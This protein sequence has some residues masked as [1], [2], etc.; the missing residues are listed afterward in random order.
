[1]SSQSDTQFQSDGEGQLWEVV[2]IT[3]EKGKKYK[4]QWAG[5]DEHGKPWPESWV[6][7]H[8]CTPDL[9]A[10]W[11]EKKAARRKSA[12]YH[13]GI[14]SSEQSYHASRPSTSSRTARSNSNATT[15]DSRR[16]LETGDDDSQLVSISRAGHNKGEA[17][18]DFDSSPPG[19]RG[20]SQKSAP[21]DKVK[22]KNVSHESKRL[23]DPEV[24]SDSTRSL[25]RHL[26]RSMKHKPSS[27]IVDNSGVEVVEVDRDLVSSTS[28]SRKDSLEPTSG[29]KRQSSSRLLTASKGRHRPDGSPVLSYSASSRLIFDH[30]GESERDGEPAVEKSPQ[31]TSKG[32]VTTDSS[33]EGLSKSYDEEVAVESGTPEATKDLSKCPGTKVKVLSRRSAIRTN[34]LDVDVT[35]TTPT[36]S[37]S[38]IPLDGRSPMPSFVIEVPKLPRRKGRLEREAEMSSDGV[39][40]G[41]AAVV[42]GKDQAVEA[43]SRVRRGA[44]EESHITDMSPAPNNT[45]SH[46]EGMDRLFYPSQSPPVPHQT[47]QVLDLDAPHADTSKLSDPSG[48]AWLDNTFAADLDDD[49]QVIMNITTPVRRS[50]L[51]RFNDDLLTLV[52]SAQDHT[53]SQKQPLVTLSPSALPSH[54]P[55]FQAPPVAYDDTHD[56]YVN[57]LPS[58]PRSDDVDQPQPM[59]TTKTADT[60]EIVP[61]TSQEDDSLPNAVQTTQDI[62]DTTHPQSEESSQIQTFDSSFRSPPRRTHDGRPL[63]LLPVVTPSRFRHHSPIEQFSSP[64]RGQSPPVLKRKRQDEGDDDVSEASEVVNVR[65]RNYLQQFADRIIQSRREEAGFPA[66]KKLRLNDVVAPQGVLSITDGASDLL[67]QQ[68][69]TSHVVEQAESQDS[70]LEPDVLAGGVSQLPE[71]DNAFMVDSGGEQSVLD[72]TIDESQE[73]VDP[74]VAR[75]QEEEENTQEALFKQL[76]DYIDYSASA[77]EPPAPLDELTTTAIDGEPQASVEEIELADVSMIVEPP[78]IVES[79]VQADTVELFMLAPDVPSS[80]VHPDG[81][82]DAK[83]LEL[84]KAEVAKLQTELVSVKED[85]EMERATL[86]DSR[87]AALKSKADLQDQLDFVEQQR[88]IASDSAFESVKENNLLK[89]RITIAETQA[90]EGV[91]MIRATFEGRVAELQADKEHLTKVIDFLIAKDQ[92]EDRVEFRKRAAEQPEYKAR[93]EELEARVA[94]L[95]DQLKVVLQP[96]PVPVQPVNDEVYPCLVME[97]DDDVVCGDTFKTKEEL[98]QHLFTSGHFLIPV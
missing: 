37:T 83:E 31:E 68:P 36:K 48:I 81:I 94:E 17:K 70:P 43:T 61:E 98:Q 53:D 76:N 29:R 74:R 24:V 25:S 42:I 73:H 32:R 95:E 97:R 85:W 52:N 91:S 18:L 59:P 1:M 4:V 16:R 63:G 27:S 57:V 12:Y 77:P 40:V 44:S 20:P 23:L 3:A 75:R 28:A 30:A 46:N 10:A 92:A 2:K 13:F 41:R 87:S 39:D 22:S 34:S 72:R 15:V 11:K 33:R 19:A 88:K 55:D 96:S 71:T 9:V 80:P 89:E 49:G 65:L 62:P 45:V 35:P 67:G 26:P 21:S 14:K 50:R 66:V 64:V 47:A 6:H 54:L 93:C 79:A 60:G 69:H 58:P 51:G 84:L 90:R 78:T 82:F 56:A 38:N 5:A 7:K 8:D 86:S